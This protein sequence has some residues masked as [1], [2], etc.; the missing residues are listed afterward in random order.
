MKSTYLWKTSTAS[1]SQSVGSGGGEVKNEKV[2]LTIPPLVLPDLLQFFIRSAPRTSIDG[3]TESVGSIADITAVDGG[4]IAVKHFTQPINISFTYSKD[5]ALYYDPDRMS[6]YSSPD[7]AIWQKEQTLIDHDT[8][9]ATASVD[10]L[11]Y[12]ALMGERRDTTA[13]RTTV[14][15][16]GQGNARSFHSDVIVELHAEDP[17][18]GST[19]DYTLFKLDEGEWGEYTAPVIITTEGAHTLQYFSADKSGN[20]ESV[21]TVEFTIDQTIP[22]I[23]MRYD[24]IT[25]DFIFSTDADA[26]INEPSTD[27]TGV[28]S[29]AAQDTAG[30]THEMRY[31]RTVGD[32]LTTLEVLGDEAGFYAI[33]NAE[34]ERYEYFQSD[35]VTRRIIPSGD[36]RLQINA[37]DDITENV[38]SPSLHIKTHHGT[39]EIDEGLD[40]KN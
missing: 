23:A 24:L 6:I 14:Q 16:S 25:K 3:H 1:Q 7:G 5:D 21:H 37:N 4:G 22:E 17:V 29:I 33:S 27:S 36:G 15:L 10:H 9:T 30:N 18:E 38:A 12:F 35:D 32:A 8:R 34:G 31:R 13:P 39:L 19:I 11:T 26:S 40:R 2:K 20:V 28:T